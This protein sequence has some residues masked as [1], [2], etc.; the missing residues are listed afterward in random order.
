MSKQLRTDD[1]RRQHPYCQE[2]KLAC[3]AAGKKWETVTS[4]CQG[5]YDE[6]DFK[7][8]AEVTGA[9][10]EVVQEL[11]NPS[12]WAFNHVGFIP[13]WYQDR[14]MR[15][16]SSRR[17][18]RMGRRTGKTE[19]M[20]LLLL[21]YALTNA[22]LKILAIAPYKSQVKEIND[23]INKFLDVNTSLRSEVTR[24]V[25][26]PYFEVVFTNGSR[27]RI[28]VSGSGSGNSS[29]DQVRGQEADLMFIDEMDYVNEDSARDSILPILSDPRRSGEPVR[30]IISSTPSGKEGLFFD[31]C[32][33]AYYREF[34]FPSYCRPDWDDDKE[35][36][37]ME[38]AKTKIG[39]EHEYLAEWS[40][41]MDGVFKRKDI[42]RAQ[43]E[44]RYAF[45]P[46]KFEEVA[47]PEMKYW[48]HWTYVMGVDWNG[49]GNGTRIGV[50]GYDPTRMKHILVYRE[51]IDVEDFSLQFAVQRVRDLNRVWRCHAIYIDSGFGQ[52]QDEIL[53]SMGE[54][55]IK[56]RA[57]GEDYEVAD[58]TLAE[59]L[60]AVDFG[61][62]ITYKAREE[63]RIV[64]KK[65]RTKHY[66]V[67]NFQRAFEN[68]AFWFSKSD[69]ELKDQLMGYTIHRFT[70]HNEPIFKADENA[71][72]HD[73]DAV[74][75]A[76]Y[77]FNREFDPIFQRPNYVLEVAQLPI[78]G[79]D[80]KP[81]QP[82]S[83][84]ENPVGWQKN[85]EEQ[86]N[87][88]MT[89]NKVA[90]RQIENSQ[91][92]KPVDFGSGI[93]IIKAPSSGKKTSGRPQLVK[94]MGRNNWLKRGQNARQFVR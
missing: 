57:M 24:S 48:P 70:Q 7:E 83:Q 59:R 8:I 38:S 56:M 3:E 32:H 72:D 75:L 17:A 52:M 85:K 27:I 18:L 47:W 80:P 45:N 73:L 60:T 89:P 86:K 9:P 74:M 41:R 19:S 77:G 35:R 1:D 64:E 43:Q 53:K 88:K 39:Y 67:E 55:A 92:M 36:E 4:N 40:T 91:K 61:S 12:Q 82:V 62:Y 10:F 15:C 51:Q 33:D 21:F 93:A 50:V 34:H 78:P 68:D 42:I 71:G 31:L 54:Q 11:Y 65:K 2:C 76:L 63:G 5:V 81:S 13:H 25:Q 28:F 69:N 90:S 37:A 20:A 79:K 46:G 94:P 87:N 6:E 84:F 26:Q 22:N 16:T 66:M 29:G 23:R 30:F 44:Y 58:I 49:P 14:A